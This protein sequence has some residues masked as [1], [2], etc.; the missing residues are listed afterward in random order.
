MVELMRD[1]QQVTRDRWSVREGCRRLE[2]HLIECF[3]GGKRLEFERIRTY[4]KKFEREMRRSNSG[5]VSESARQ[6]LAVARLK[7][8]LFGWD[9][10]TWALV[11]DPHQLETAGYKITLEPIDRNT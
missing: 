3:I 2:K 8:D 7:R 10:S 6:L 9:I 1:R 4:Y 5:A 11:L